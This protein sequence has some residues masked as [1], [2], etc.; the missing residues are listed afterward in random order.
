MDA[1]S[2]ERVSVVERAAIILTGLSA[3]MVVNYP[4]WITAKRISAGLT[5]PPT[6]DIYKGSGSLLLAMGPMIVVQDATTAVVLRCLDGWLQ[7]TAALAASACSSGAIGALTVGAQIEAL[8]TR[9]HATKASIGQTAA[10]VYRMGGLRALLVPH[11]M[12]M[13]A[14]RETP[15]AGCLFFLSGWIRSQ[16]DICCQYAPWGDDSKSSNGEKRVSVLRDVAAAILTASV[17]GPISQV[18]NVIAAHQQAHASTIKAS[19]RTIVESSGLRGLYGGLMTRTVSLAGSL[20]IFPFTIEIVQPTYE[21]W[22]RRP[23]LQ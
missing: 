2:R 4:L 9:A 16:I 15:Y 22:R 7:P 14:A 21:E 18:P 13:I 20:F 5:L 1:S 23:F 8:I 12:T 11:G 10:N 3:D 6:A 19:V 17:A